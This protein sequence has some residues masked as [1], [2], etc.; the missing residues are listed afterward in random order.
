VVVVVVVAWSEEE[1]DI[2]GEDVDVEDVDGTFLGLVV[3]MVH[4]CFEVYE[5]ILGWVGERVWRYE[6]ECQ[7]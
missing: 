3:F 2:T 7:C 1:E 4:D 5:Y 6:F